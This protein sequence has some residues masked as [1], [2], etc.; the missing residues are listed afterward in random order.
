MS[1]Y[2]VCVIRLVPVATGRTT[3][4]D[5][6]LAYLARAV[7]ASLCGFVVSAQFVTC[8]F[9]EVPYYVGLLGAGVLKLS[10]SKPQAAQGR[11][12]PGPGVFGPL[13]PTRT[14]YPMSRVPR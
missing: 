3:V 9:L 10:S 13:T 14:G 7:I 8:E 12:T 4:P 5:P 2:G 6:W 1:Y 11:R